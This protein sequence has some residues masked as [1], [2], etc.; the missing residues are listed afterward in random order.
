M[1][2]KDIYD[3]FFCLDLDFYSGNL[4]KALK[5]TLDFYKVNQASFLNELLLRLKEARKNTYYIGNSTNHFIPRNLRPDW[6]VFI[7]T[8]MLKIERALREVK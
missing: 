1:E 6:K 2:G 5:I 7:D 4:L 3:L 8:L